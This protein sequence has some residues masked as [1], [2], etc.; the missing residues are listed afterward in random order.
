MNTPDVSIITP[1]R[2]G[3]RFIEAALQ[4]V[5]GQTCAAVEH[6]IVDGAS[7]DGT[8]AILARYHARYPDRV[9]FISEPDRGG[10]EGFNKGCRMAR[11]RI[12]GWL[13]SDD[14]SCADAARQ[15]VA[16]LDAHPHHDVVYGEADFIDG[17]GRVVGRFATRDFSVDRAINEGACVA[18]PA[19][20]YRRHVVDQVGG[21]RVG[22]IVCDH[23]WLIRVGTRFALTRLPLTLCQ[24]RL[25][26]GST[27]ASAGERIYPRGNFLA[28]R[29]HGGRL[30][31][32]VSMRYYRSLLFEVPGVRL[33]WER[34]IA[35]CG[36][37]LRFRDRDR[38]L[39]I[40]GAALSGFRCLEMLE[41]EHRQ[42]PLFIDNWPSGARAY[43]GR[44]VYTPAEFMDRGQ[45]AVDAVIIAT[46]ASSRY[47]QTM[48]RQL[49]ALGFSRPVYC[50][51][52][53]S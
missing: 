22:D 42:V 32:P 51:G 26:E 53:S 44:P 18:F 30:L 46:A 9:R 35:S 14:L 27:S 3:A 40:F 17:Q 31:S 12:L 39:A 47:A 37:R 36:F 28:S 20:F 25:H 21:F 41:R 6:V 45:G 49:R 29:R 24:F 2:N 23:E 8:P 5:L 48:R 50:F 38:R 10:C 4:S 13:G 15:V 34:A 1:V 19:V 7:D 52:F 33:V 11:G 43:C 16:H